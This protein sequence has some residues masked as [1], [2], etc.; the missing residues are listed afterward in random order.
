MGDSS[1]FYAVRRPNMRTVVKVTYNSGRIEHHDYGTARAAE[2]ARN[3]F[4]TIDTVRRA[5]VL[6]RKARPKHE[7]SA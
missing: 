7:V 3:K 4:L 6:K 2:A 1:D 5:T